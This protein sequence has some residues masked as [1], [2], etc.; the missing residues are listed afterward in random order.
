MFPTFRIYQKNPL[1]INMVVDINKPE[2]RDKSVDLSK[3]SLGNCLKYKKIH[4]Y[5][6]T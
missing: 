2:I 5:Y 4:A 1:P 6:D 3:G